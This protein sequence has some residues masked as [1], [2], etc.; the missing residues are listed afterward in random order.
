MNKSPAFQLY[1]ADF[2]ADEDV[3]VMSLAARGA[4]ITL[5]CFNWRE[6]SIPADLDR[7]GRLCGCD[8]SVI[9]ELWEEIGR[10]FEESEGDPSRLVNPRLKEE[11][12]RQ[13]EHRAKQVAAGHK[14]ANSRWER[15]KRGRHSTNGVA[16]A[17]P[18]ATPMA[19]D[20]SSPSSSSSNKGSANAGAGAPSVIWDVGLAL[21]T[22]AGRTERDA[23][24]FLGKQIK[25]YSEQAVADV[26]AAASLKRPADPVPY[27]VAA[28][29]NKFSGNKPRED[30]VNYPP[31]TRCTDEEEAEIVA[32]YL[33]DGMPIGNYPA[34][35]IERIDAMG[36][37]RTPR[38]RKQRSVLDESDGGPYSEPS[39][40]H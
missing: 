15:S 36:L 33:R 24:G 29:K 25:I 30:D 7:I 9:R 19:N 39:S 14:G 32:S 35:V 2:L 4:Y 37:D 18:M 38:P 1:A 22:A 23:R 3:M 6:G 31:P 21:L 20:S 27:I 26:I 17:T 34:Y 16:K 10:C 12:K 5:L 40:V 8:G 13:E 11:R 28:L